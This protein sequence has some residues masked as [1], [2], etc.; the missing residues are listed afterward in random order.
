MPTSKKGTNVYKQAPTELIPIEREG[1]IHYTRQK[2]CTRM[3]KFLCNTPT[4]GSQY[5]SQ[6]TEIFQSF[7]LSFGFYLQRNYSFYL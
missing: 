5:I 2:H 1:T 4:Q 6:L 7:L 3:A